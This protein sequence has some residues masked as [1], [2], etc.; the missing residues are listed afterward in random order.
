MLLNSFG[1]GAGDQTG[2]AATGAASSAPTVI[3][4]LLS[5]VLVACG[6]GPGPDTNS[7]AIE[8]APAADMKQPSATTATVALKQSG[9]GLV[10]DFQFA[11]GSAEVTFCSDGPFVRIDETWKSAKIETDPVGS[12]PMKKRAVGNLRII[13]DKVN[14]QL[15]II[16]LDKN[17]FVKIN[18]ARMAEARIDLEKG[19][20]MSLGN[21][22][23]KSKAA[24]PTDSIPTPMVIPLPSNTPKKNHPKGCRVFERDLPLG[25]KEETCFSAFDE[26]IAVSDA[27]SPLISAGSFTS[28]LSVR[29]PELNAASA[30]AEAIDWDLGIPAAQFTFG[31]SPFEEPSSKMDPWD[32][33][34]TLKDQRPCT[35]HPK[36]LDPPKDATEEFGL[37]PWE[38]P[39]IVTALPD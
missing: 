34:F 12:N 22:G 14:K 21:L 8:P 2:A 29:V 7:G 32:R 9:R 11:D 10:Y 5:A 36:D 6:K 38:T 23:A 31:D 20:P 35:I 30:V 37:I 33:V 39:F 24:A 17:S 18:E 27:F 16:N 19:T 1:S 26:D 3:V 13:Y 25:L 15:T 4:L 28:E